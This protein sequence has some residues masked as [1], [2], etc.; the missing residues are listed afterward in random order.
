[1]LRRLTA[2][3]GIV[4]VLGGVV[5]ASRYQPLSLT[6][7]GG[8]WVS[9]STTQIVG[10][11]DKV[12]LVNGGPLGVTVTSLTPVITANVRIVSDSL[13]PC[14][15]SPTSASDPTISCRDGARD[16][17]LLVA[18]SSRYL[19][20]GHSLLTERAFTLS[21]TGL[22]RYVESQVT[23]AAYAT[24]RFGWFTHRVLLPFTDKVHLASHYCP[25]AG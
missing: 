16:Q 11:S 10:V 19:A 8:R 9:S 6:N 23:L 12:A 17:I 3:L 20:G 15:A 18:L 13:S 22:A 4:V 14:R 24:Y 2:L 21:C 25:I 5:A 1:M 7:Y